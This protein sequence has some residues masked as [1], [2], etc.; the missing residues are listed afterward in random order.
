MATTSVSTS[1][2]ANIARRISTRYR[3]ARRCKRKSTQIGNDSLFH[4]LLIE[5]AI[6]RIGAQMV[7]VLPG[8]GKSGYRPAHVLR[9]QPRTRAFLQRAAVSVP[10]NFL[11]MRTVFLPSR[12][13]VRTLPANKAHPETKLPNPYELHYWP[14][15]QSSRTLAGQG[16]DFHAP[17]GAP[18]A[19]TTPRTL[20]T[21]HHNRFSGVSPAGWLFRARTM[22]NSA[23]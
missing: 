3:R 23:R 16:L 12:F 9:R 11:R 7:K 18:V 21:A 22:G 10:P 6:E 15:G 1:E 20:R 8:E 14:T 17:S 13:L 19:P 4:F 5:Y 2:T